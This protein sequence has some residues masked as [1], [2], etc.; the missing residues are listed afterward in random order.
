M[1][2]WLD[3]IWVKVNDLSLSLYCLLIICT[4]SAI[5]SRLIFQWSE[6]WEIQ[7]NVFIVFSTEEL[8]VTWFWV[9]SFILMCLFLTDL[10]ASQCCWQS[11]PVRITQPLVAPHYMWHLVYIQYQLFHL[12]LH[13]CKDWQIYKKTRGETGIY[14]ENLLFYN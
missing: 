1:T 9:C 5:W 8:N 2:V 11:N 6:S 14:W 13:L 7:T 4:D 10:F 12:L 3:N